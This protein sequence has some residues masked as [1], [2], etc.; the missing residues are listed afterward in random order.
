MVILCII[1]HL[2]M[3]LMSQF[4][5]H[6]DITVMNEAADELVKRFHAQL[7]HTPRISLYDSDK[8]VALEIPREIILYSFQE[9]H[10][11]TGN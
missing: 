5:Q 10:T 4:P 2:Y 6:P 1:M 9:K 11:A 3:Q 7:D 8:G